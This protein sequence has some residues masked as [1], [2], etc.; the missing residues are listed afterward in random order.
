MTAL[1]VFTGGAV[2]A[3]VLGTAAL[4]W[5]LLGGMGHH[6]LA[7]A[8]TL[9]IGAVYAV[10][11]AE[12]W[13]F[14]RDTGALAGAVERLQADTP[15]PAWLDGLPSTLRQ[16]VRRR[17]AGAAAPLPGPALTP[18]LV[19]LLVLLGM[20]GTFLGLVV[21]L[22]GTVA[23]LERTSDLAAMRAALA[24]PVKGLGLAFGTSV[25]GV[26]ASAM[27]GLMSA[28]LRRVRGGVQLALD[29]QA[30]T[31]L[32]DATP[33]AQRAR[34]LED[35]AR[36]LT[37]QLATRLENATQAQATV[38]PA[39]VDQV[40]ALLHRLEAQQQARQ[41][42]EQAQ[43]AAFQQAM[44]AQ[45]ETLATRVATTLDTTLGTTVAQA[46]R[47]SLADGAQ[48]ASSALQAAATAAVDGIARESAAVQARLADSTQA[49][50]QALDDLTQGHLQGLAERSQAQVQAL[51]ARTNAQVQT[52][53][54]GTQTQLQTLA[55]RFEATAERIGQALQQQAGALAEGV[56][57]AHEGLQDRAEAREAQRQAEQSAAMQT[58]A[59]TLQQRA[60]EDAAAAQARQSAWSDALAQ[61]T[62]AL[63][64]QAATQA[65]DIVAE[66]ARLT[67]TA[68]EAPRAA[69]AVIAEMREQL[70][71]SQ[72]RDAALLDE[73][74]RLTE[75]LSALVEDSRQ[76]AAAQQAAVQRLVDAAD[77][78]VERSG[79]AVVQHWQAA[80]A[81]QGDA[82]TRLAGGAVE[83]ASLGEAFGA[84]VA[85]FAHT[86]GTLA[87]QLQRVESALDQAAVRHDEQL[88]YYVAQAREVIDLSLGAQQPLLDAM[89]PLLTALQ[90]I[91][92][93]AATVDD[94]AAETTDAG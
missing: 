46:L 48:A 10:G 65:R 57:R 90:R 75:A 38:L 47:D 15:L 72:A 17:I 94:E 68:A 12:L 64:Q 21:T 92:G 24:A 6:P 13:R 93:P 49:S 31:L 87:D 60:A 32:Q 73:R 41:Q 1:R 69:A 14:H 84:A 19:G 89:P 37:D 29:R 27:L 62:E 44:Q 9:G 78:L 7:L 56:A 74:V 55:Q 88:A 42:H 30:S 51:E 58:L 26:A 85:Q 67:A 45:F 25:A 40:Q 36:Q 70:G 43:Q 59:R 63:Q 28:L 50:L 71:T 18:Y 2:L 61:R 20:L 91:A 8:M 16:P 80:L 81:Q 4:V 22:D 77:G 3:G 5:V 79:E 33:A 11:I 76:A 34:H 83:V 39:L 82:A 53:V 35:L 66:V 23:A 52:L 86:A 54:D